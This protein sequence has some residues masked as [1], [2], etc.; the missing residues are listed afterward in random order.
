M[1]RT[2][3]STGRSVWFVVDNLSRGRVQKDVHGRT[4]LHILC[5]IAASKEVIE[6]LLKHCPGVIRE[7][8]NTI[9]MPLHVVCGYRLTSMD[10]IEMLIDHYPRALQIKGGKNGCLPLHLAC[11]NLVKGNNWVVA[12]SQPA[13]SSREKQVRRDAVARRL[14]ASG[15]F[16]G[17]VR[18]VGRKLSKSSPREA[19]VRRHAIASSMYI[20]RPFQ[21]DGI[22]RWETSWGATPGEQLRAY[23]L[24]SDL[25]VK[26]YREPLQ[27]KGCTLLHVACSLPNVKKR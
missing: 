5:S 19:A 13:G 18:V 22:V 10:V 2:Y 21:G 17:G 25:L 8:C 14:L 24:G 26:H 4:P 27:R 3:S 6:L 1:L 16:G 15:G 12:C 7:Q 11:A 20:L 23:S 9:G